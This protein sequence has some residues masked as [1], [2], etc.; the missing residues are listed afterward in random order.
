MSRTKPKQG[1][2]MMSAATFKLV[3]V[4]CEAK[5]ER[6]AEDCKEQPF[7]EKCYSP[8]ILDRVT[9]RAR[10]TPETKEEKR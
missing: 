10:R 5:D 1:E 4:S 7:C 3:C 9:V 2:E 8:M 6:H